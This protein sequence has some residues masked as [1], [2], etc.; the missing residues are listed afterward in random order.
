MSNFFISLELLILL[1]YD[2]TPDDF[3]VL[4]FVILHDKYS[5]SFHLPKKY[6]FK[7]KIC[8]QITIFDL[9]YF[10]K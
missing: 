10:L 1:A 6:L 7:V 8:F 3:L 5:C 4:L 2:A 9:S